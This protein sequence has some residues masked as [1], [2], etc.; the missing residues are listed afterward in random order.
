MQTKNSCLAVA[1]GPNE[2]YLYSFDPND[3]ASV[4]EEISED[5]EN[6]FKLT[7]FTV[8]DTKT[9]TR[10]GSFDLVSEQEDS[11]DAYSLPELYTKR[12]LDRVGLE[13]L[14]DM[15]VEISDF[16]YRVVKLAARH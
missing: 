16:R 5:A 4:I 8:S 15:P 11:S 3:C 1:R 14:E 12:L 9:S 2:I 6:S 13:L 7:R 10:F